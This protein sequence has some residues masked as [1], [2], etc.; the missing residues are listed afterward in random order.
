MVYYNI[1]IGQIFGDRIV[2]ERVENSKNGFAQFLCKC[3]CGR[4]SVVR[5][6]RLLSGKCFKCKYCWSDSFHNIQSPCHKAGNKNPNYKGTKNVSYTYFSRIQRGA[7]SRKLEF[8]ITID[9]LQ[10]LLENQEFKCK[11]SGINLIM[12]ASNGVKQNYLNTGSVDRIDSLKGYI[13]GNIQWVHK[14]INVMKQDLTD[15]D[16]I[17]WCKIISKHNS[18]TRATSCSIPKSKFSL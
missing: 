18:T 15:N 5:G 8:N 9:Y 13:E 11:L 16:F 3:K 6:V 17:E 1:R 7:K 14:T 12:N 10:S 4:T 2:I